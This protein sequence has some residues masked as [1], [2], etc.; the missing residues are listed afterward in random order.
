MPAMCSLAASTKTPIQLNKNDNAV[1]L[2][3]LNST[4]RRA[5]LQHRLKSWISVK[6]MH[7]MHP[8]LE[9]LGGGGGEGAA[10]GVLERVNAGALLRVALDEAQHSF[11]E[12][13]QRAQH[14]TC[15]LRLLPWGWLLAQNH[16]CC[17]QHG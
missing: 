2:F 6:C 17:L 12:D 11:P 10:A 4:M 16:R 14:G 5:V 9:V 7:C 8:G 1:P 3:S 15:C 13:P